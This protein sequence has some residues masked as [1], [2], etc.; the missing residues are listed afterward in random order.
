MHNL[1]ARRSGEFSLA[2]TILALALGLLLALAVPRVSEAATYVGAATGDVKPADKAVIASPKPVQLLFQFK[3]KGAPNGAATKFTKDKV[4][5]AVKDSGLFSEVS[6]GPVAGGAILNVVIDN[7]VEPGAISE[8]TGKGFVTGATFFIAGS[9]TTDHYLCT[10]D[11]L[12]APD[13]A[14]ITRTATHTLIMQMGLINSPPPN[15]VRI[16]R[17][18]DAVFTLVRQIVANPLNEIGRDPA[19]AGGAT[20][21]AP[22]TAIAAS[23]APTPPAVATPAPA[24]AGATPVPVSPMAPAASPMAPAV[25]PAAAAEPAPAGPGE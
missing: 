5:Q 9:N 8:A 23:A 21:A 22:V 19:F 25:S 6:E 18:D 17:M 14:K 12:G 1:A 4:T 16:G 15:A 24:P 3:T 13:A 2:C 10:V 11:Y 20:A 7:V